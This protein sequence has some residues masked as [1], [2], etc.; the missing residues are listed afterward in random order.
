MPSRN[1]VVAP[2]KQGPLQTVV[3]PNPQPT[4]TGPHTPRPPDPSE[5]KGTKQKARRK[6]K[7]ATAGSRGTLTRN[8]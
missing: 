7:A 2:I 6:P 1:R 5:L 8:R 4:G 3:V